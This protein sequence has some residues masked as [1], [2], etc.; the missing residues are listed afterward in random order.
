MSSVQGLEVGR[1]L[2][3]AGAQAQRRVVRDAGPRRDPADLVAERSVN[4]RLPSGPAV[5]RRVAAGR[6]VGNS[7]IDAGRRDP[8]DLV[9][10][11]SVNQRLP[12]GP[13]VIPAGLLLAVGIGNR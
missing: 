11:L 3:A 10:P 4:Q 6:R 8:A 2:E 7:V 9:R 12:S 13:A 1:D 5:I